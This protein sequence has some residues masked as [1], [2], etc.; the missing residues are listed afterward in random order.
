[1]ARARRAPASR[2]PPPSEPHRLRTR[3]RPRPPRHPQQPQR[4]RQHA[5]R[6]RRA[7]AAAQLHQRNL[8]D[9]ERVL[10][11]DHPDTLSSRSNLANAL[12]ELDEHRQATEL[13][14][15][16]LTDHERV[17]GHDHPHTL[18]SRH[19]LANARARLAEVGRRRWWQLPRR[20]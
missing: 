3:P 13:H 7:P 18:N 11:H 9:R 16:N 5:E 10:G 2:R 12:F 20:R 6:P 15:Q 17:L 19:N 14:R 8:T 1:M 4:P